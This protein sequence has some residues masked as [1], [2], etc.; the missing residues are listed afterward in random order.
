MSNESKEFSFG[1]MKQENSETDNLIGKEGFDRRMLSDIERGGSSLPMEGGDLLEDLMGVEIGE[2][3][4]IKELVNVLERVRAFQEGLLDTN[5]PFELDPN[6]LRSPE[7]RYMLSYFRNLFVTVEG[8]T[9]RPNTPYLGIQEKLVVEEP[10]RESR[11]WR[12]EPGKEEYRKKRRE[13]FEKINKIRIQKGRKVITDINDRID[14]ELNLLEKEHLARKKLLG[15]LNYLEAR[16]SVDSAFI[17]RMYTCEN[18]EQASKLG[19]E[20]R[21]VSPDGSTWESFFHTEGF[22]DFGQ[23]V[24]DIFEEIVKFGMTEEDVEKFGMTETPDKKVREKVCKN[25]GDIAKIGVYADGFKNTKAFASW[26]KHLIEK[27]DGRVD[28]VWSAWKLALIWEV[29]EKLGI[30]IKKDKEPLKYALA[31][32]PVG[33][34]L[35]GWTSHLKEKRKGEF[36]LDINGKRYQPEKFMTH[37]GLPLSIDA[38]PNLCEDFLHEKKIEFNKAELDNSDWGKKLSEVLKNIKDRLPK[39]RNSF[40]YTEDYEKLKKDLDDFFSKGDKKSVKVSLWDLRIIGGWKFSDPLFPWLTSDRPPIGESDVGE[41][42]RGAFGAWLL[43]RARAFKVLTDIRSRP[44]LNELGD[45]DFFAS[46]IRN[47]TKVLG[48]I[49]DVPEG[50]KDYVS[51]EDNPRAAWL[52]SIFRYYTSGPVAQKPR[53]SNWNDEYD[54]RVPE[55]NLDLSWLLPGRAKSSVSMGDVLFSATQCGFLRKRDAD[56]ILHSLRV[57]LMG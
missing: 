16:Q 1:D 40:L 2:G 50:H 45:P 44:A 13:Q 4:D 55:R 17:Q 53:L 21:A 29:P 26:L 15:V 51:P 9:K 34:S 25:E 28:I 18:P 49:K 11:K 24:D 27:A 31:T 3:G 10:L 14:K 52:L 41:L 43:K 47:W 36:G 32:P 42:P 54:Y 5:L 8:A 48:S 35:I 39:N 23:K 20:I 6:N 7:T 56:W 46:R 33:N 37:S 19:Q 57:G 22:S 38:I 12:G 30:Y